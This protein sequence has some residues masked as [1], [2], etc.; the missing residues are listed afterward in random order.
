MSDT[1]Q[2][3]SLALGPL[4]ANCFV[5]ARGTD[6]VV[7]DPGDDALAVV[8]LVARLEVSPCA[9]LLT[10]GHFDH[11]GAAQ[12]LATTWQVPVYVGEHDAAEVARPELAA[13]AGVRV[14]PVSDTPI[15]L[16]GEQEL[17]LPIAVTA[18]PTP[19]HSAGSYTFSIEGHL[20]S[21]DLIFYGSVGR[22]A[23]PGGSARVLMDSIEM[24]VGRFSPE[25]MVHCGHGPDTTLGRELAINPF[26]AGLRRASQADA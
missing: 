2:V 14:T 3:H 22:S 17:A 4:A 10:H 24:L 18:L 5:V 13:M 20:F 19:G 7:I 12:P 11:M 26:F 16:T 1:L 6:A 23:L 15:L 21:G 9:V 25:T 8:R